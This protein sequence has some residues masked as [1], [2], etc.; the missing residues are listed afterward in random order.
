MEMGLA[1]PCT[2]V[3]RDLLIYPPYYPFA[4]HLVFFL[5]EGLVE[6]GINPL[7]AAGRA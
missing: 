6:A 5:K 3:G 1:L 4:A 2:S 7:P